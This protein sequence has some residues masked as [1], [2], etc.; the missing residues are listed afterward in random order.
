MRVLVCGATGCVGS[1]VANALR[2][3][4]H[5]VVAG[6]RAHADGPHTMHV[7]FMVPVEPSAWAQRLTAQRIEAIVNCVGILIPARGQ[8]FER[9]HALGP[10]EL[11]RGAAAAGVTRVLQVSALGVNHDAQSLATPYLH[12]KLRADDALAALPV[13]AAVLRPSLV[14]GPR[15]QS[16]RLFATLASLPVISLPG[17]GG[18]PVQP[19]HV[20]ELAEAMV[21]LIE[22]PEAVK[23]TYEIAGPAVL[24]YREMLAAYRHAQGLGDAV[25]LPLPMALM[26]LGALAAEALPQKVFSRDTL[27]ML[28][29]GSVTEVNAL[30]SLLAR[31]PSTL[32]HGLAVTRPEPMLDLR[33]RISPAVAW[34]VRGALA[35]MWIYTALISALLP[36]QS[37]VLHLLARCGFE[38]RVGV[39]VLIASC[40]M[41]LLLGTL[42]LVRPSPW[43]YAVQCGAV[44][45]YGLTA[46]FNM[47][48]LTLDHCAPLVKNVPV[49][50]AVMLLWLAHPARPTTLRARPSA[51]RDGATLPT[52]VSWR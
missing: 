29:R 22:R 16:A 1:A 31:A 36:T 51:E 5:Q 34:A 20:F 46:A 19:V 8:S 23:G 35:F 21:R 39:A 43:L 15:S 40:S 17:W 26:K 48:E 13:D 37:G 30:P 18:Q 47:P 9:V 33:V 49:L 50:M 14:Y 41:N 42:T 7:D 12:S 32:A 52:M 10:I 2:A 38:G 3:R 6:A 4:G 27:R 25:W 24:S 11:F 44:L 45:G 28:E